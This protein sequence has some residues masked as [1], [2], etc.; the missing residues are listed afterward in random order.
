[1]NDWTAAPTI[2]G[3]TAQDYDKFL[4]CALTM[5]GTER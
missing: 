5:R 2:G 3:S 4:N 1:M